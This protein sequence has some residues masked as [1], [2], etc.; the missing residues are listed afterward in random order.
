MECIKTDRGTPDLSNVI[1]SSSVNNGYCLDGNCV[2]YFNT[3]TTPD[4]S[5]ISVTYDTPSDIPIDTLTI[6][7]S[8]IK[9]TTEL[10]GSKHYEIEFYG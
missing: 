1:T 3:P 7:N 8:P 10:N 5:S 2:K 6:T 9:I 4:E